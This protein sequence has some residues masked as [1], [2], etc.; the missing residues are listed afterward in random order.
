MRMTADMTRAIFHTHSSIVGTTEDGQK[1]QEKTARAEGDATDTHPIDARMEGGGR[2]GSEGTRPASRPRSQALQQ[3]GTLHTFF[4]DSTRH[5]EV[6]AGGQAR[7]PPATGDEQPPEALAG[8][9]GRDPRL[10]RIGERS[11]GSVVEAT[12]L[13]V[14]PLPKSGQGLLGV[15]GIRPLPKSG[16]R[17]LGVAPR[18]VESPRCIESPFGAGPA[19][20]GDAIGDTGDVVFESAGSFSDSGNDGSSLFLGAVRLSMSPSC[21]A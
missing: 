20:N 1:N 11:E 16:Q 14:R 19:P 7:D 6:M 4:G 2:G 17:L 15:A 13:G 21:T 3:W 8:A 10:E 9:R 5:A 12:E 18:C